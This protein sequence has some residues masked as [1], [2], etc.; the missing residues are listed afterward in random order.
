MDG[1]GVA[2][3]DESLGAGVFVGVEGASVG[4][5]IGASVGGGVGASVGGGVGLSLI[6]I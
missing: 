5:G 2:G 1:G 3:L 6:H 4:G